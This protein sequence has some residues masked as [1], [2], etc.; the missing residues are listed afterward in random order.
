[1]TSN[2]QRERAYQTERDYR[3]DVAAAVRGQI[4]NDQ[5]DTVGSVVDAM[6]G[7]RDLRLEQL[8]VQAAA[9]RSAA[10]V[11]RDEIA[12]VLHHWQCGCT[13]GP[14][15][16]KGHH[17]KPIQYPVYMEAADGVLKLFRDVEKHRR[18]AEEAGLDDFAV[19]T[20]RRCRSAI[21]NHDGRANPAWSTGE[22]LAVALVL[23]DQE[24]LD[25]MEYSRREAIDRVCG[26]M[27]N[28]PSNFAA[29]AAT[30]R[31]KL[32]ISA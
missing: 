5:P 30:I 21:R 24:T 7:V 11:T 27:W 19:D 2:D 23:G 15:S 10:S 32:G 13:I 4:G 14:D 26:G 16:P 29:W 3:Q 31:T 28:P 22:K 12:D 17:L 9:G 25:E 6:L 1:M 8:A 20:L 18:E